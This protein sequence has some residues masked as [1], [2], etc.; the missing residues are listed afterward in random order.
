MRPIPYGSP[1]GFE[2]GSAH[3]KLLSRFLALTPAD[4]TSA[5]E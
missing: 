2:T 4:L 3:R 5:V 1:Y